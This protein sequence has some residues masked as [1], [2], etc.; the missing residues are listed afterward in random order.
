MKTK[1]LPIE[2]MTCAACSS[3]VERAVRKLPGV[4]EAN[5]N[6]TAENL[7]LSYD[8]SQV[9]LENVVKAVDDAGY[10]A[11]IPSQH[12]QLEVHGM[13]CASCS[14]TVERVVG[15]LPGVQNANVNLASETLTLDYDP[16]EI[17]LQQVVGAVAEAGYQAILPVESTIED[18]LERKKAHKAKRLQNLKTRFISSAILTVPLLVLSMGPMLGLKLPAFFDPA[19]NS[20]NNALAQLLLT[21]PVVIMGWSYYVN[22]IRN[23]VKMRPNM[24]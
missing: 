10:K 21:T 24:D 14:A 17:S 11:V 3:A 19:V 5:V 23:L 22:G 18:E 9:S 15:K 7:H 12:V 4:T 1:T 13:T 2:G 16:A 8:E 20:F 6:L